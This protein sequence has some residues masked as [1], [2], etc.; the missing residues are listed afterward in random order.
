[1]PT[2]DQQ[3]GTEPSASPATASSTIR[4]CAGS[5]AAPANNTPP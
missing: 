1:M 3:A 2:C 4:I 5:C